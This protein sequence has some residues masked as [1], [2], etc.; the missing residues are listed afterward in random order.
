MQKHSIYNL[1]KIE[2]RDYL[3]VLLC[4]IARLQKQVGI[5]EGKADHLLHP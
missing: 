4:V 1:V 5:V 3:P 2:Q